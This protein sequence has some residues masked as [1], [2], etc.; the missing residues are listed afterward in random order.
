M[1]KGA[2]SSRAFFYVDTV[3]TGLKIPKRFD[4]WNLKKYPSKN[5]TTGEANVYLFFS[6]P[7][8]SN[9]FWQCLLLWFNNFVECHLSIANRVNYNAFNGVAVCIVLRNERRPLVIRDVR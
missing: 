7:I 4:A 8:K 5:P 6:I 3:P 9:R 2:V 1:N